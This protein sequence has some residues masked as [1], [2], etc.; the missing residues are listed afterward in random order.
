MSLFPSFPPLP[1]LLLH[2]LYFL[3]HFR[4]LSITTNLTKKHVAHTILFINGI[5]IYF[6]NGSVQGIAIALYAC[7][8][9]LYTHAISRY[10]EFWLTPNLNSTCCHHR[11]PK[12]AFLRSLSVYE[13]R[14]KMKPSPKHQ[15]DKNGEISRC[16]TIEVS[17]Q[18]VFAAIKSL[19]TETQDLTP[20]ESAV[21][22]ITTIQTSTLKYRWEGLLCCL[23][24][25]FQCLSLTSHLFSL[26]LK[27]RHRTGSC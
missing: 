24:I 15:Q 13:T 25:C 3:Y 6:R 5:L 10:N 1:L 27:A 17:N 21:L 2:P 19:L 11:L 20:R 18:D 9:I 14:K 22:G 12:E 8:F 23:A 26:S 7:L 16:L 4:L